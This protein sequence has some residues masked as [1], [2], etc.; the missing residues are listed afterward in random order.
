M[1]TYLRYKQFS[2]KNAQPD[3]FGLAHCTTR[4]EDEEAWVDDFLKKL[5]KRRQK[6]YD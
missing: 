5:W 1:K 3:K 6:V 4:R 2:E